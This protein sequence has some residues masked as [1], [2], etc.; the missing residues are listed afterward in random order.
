MP[1][2]LFTLLAHLALAA[3]MHGQSDSAQSAF[4][5][6][7]TVAILQGDGVVNSLPRPLATRVSIRVADSKGQP[8]RD[9]V[10]VLEFPVAGASATFPDGSV[11]KT[12][13]TNANGE[14]TATLR[15]NEVPG[16]YRPM[17]TVNYLGQSSVVTL[18]QENA[19]EFSAP[20]MPKKKSF[21]ARL[22]SKRT[23]LIAAGATATVVVAIVA[24]GSSP[25][26]QPPNDGI[27]ITP[28]TGTVG[29]R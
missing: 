4:N 1:T 2:R 22:F 16:K 21:F 3:N 7:F 18:H 15:S 29:S 11:V 24:R 27:T 28:G 17:I 26:P 5:K 8:I 19:Y 9:A 12:L 14:A 25:A 23:A 10:A 13:L 20:P 6:G